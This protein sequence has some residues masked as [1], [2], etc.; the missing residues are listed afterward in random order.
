M[1]RSIRRIEFLDEMAPMDTGKWHT[2]M[3]AS[4]EEEEREASPKWREVD[5]LMVIW[6]VGLSMPRQ[7]AGIPLMRLLLM[8]NR[9]E[10]ANFGPSP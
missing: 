4:G 5:N 6:L 2:I 10:Q 7:S 8:V 3:V 1:N 9:H